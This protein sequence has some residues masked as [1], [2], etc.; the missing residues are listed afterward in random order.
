MITLLIQMEIE[1][2]IGGPCMHLVWPAK[3]HCMGVIV[4]NNLEVQSLM[5][6][7]MSAEPEQTF[8][9][10]PKAFNES[11]LAASKGL[12]ASSNA[13]NAS[14]Q[15]VRRQG[16]GAE[17]TVEPRKL[18]DSDAGPLPVRSHP[19]VPSQKAHL[20]QTIPVV[21]PIANS[22]QWRFGGAV[23]SKMAL[24][25]DSADIEI[26]ETGVATPIVPSEAESPSA[27]SCYLRAGLGQS[28]GS[29]SGADLLQ[30]S[31]GAVNSKVQN[32]KAQV[33]DSS[34]AGNCA[35]DALTSSTVNA[36]QTVGP[37]TAQKSLP[38]TVL[39]ASSSGTS[40]EAFNAFPSGIAVGNAGVIHGRTR[41]ET[42]STDSPVFQRAIPSVVQDADSKACLNNALK[43][44][45]APVTEAVLSPSAK[46]DSASGP[47]SISVDP[48]AAR[49][50]ANDQDGSSNGISVPS[51]ESDQ[52]S[53]LISPSGG[54]LTTDHDL[55]SRLSSTP[56]V[57]TP[58]TTSLNS[59][60]G[61]KGLANKTTGLKQQPQPTTDQSSSRSGSQGV[62]SSGEQNQ[63][64]N[65]SQDQGTAATQVSLAN[66]ATAGTAHA[67]S[68]VAASPVPMSPT[69]EGATGSAAKTLDSSAPVLTAPQLAPPIINT[70]KL[71]Q[72]LGQSEMR[73]GMRSSEFGNISISTSSTRD[74][75]SAQISLDHG[76][77][78]KTLATHLLEMQSRW[79]SDQ[80][81][82]L[83][84]GLNG[85]G[86]GAS[87]GMLNPTAGE[88]RGNR[89]QTGGSTAGH[90]GGVLVERQ[91]SSSVQ[92]VSAGE[93]RLDARL[94][95]RV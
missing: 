33:A 25:E 93:G 42:L 78:A 20:I 45:L 57:K 72:S 85:Q 49:E 88:S 51:G 86:I 36:G 64:A 54:M 22:A 92:A 82:D 52:F 80:A 66:H 5:P 13:S 19:T 69:H 41:G 67:Q 2:S 63:G 12:V 74:Q 17:D 16:R 27:Q 44:V 8:S 29:G 28:S 30:H 59:A 62:T 48:A 58:I 77:L 75:I 91:S 10:L 70:A 60:E 34:R 7:M 89:E 15:I 68:V 84:I 24:R 4:K 14:T 61:D 90:S 43:A 35:S 94:D 81:V 79:S 39:N 53:T 32:F 31:S 50:V 83:R 23:E 26:R 3:C 95:I 87:G 21:I 40:L 73:V 46:A 11:L 18:P 55:T 76:E 1:S 6:R 9:Q 37:D 38:P 65:L 47:S 56:G 71:I